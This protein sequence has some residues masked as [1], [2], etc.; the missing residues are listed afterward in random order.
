MKNP[1]LTEIEEFFD[2]LINYP[3]NIKIDGH[4]YSE[5]AIKKLIKAEIIIL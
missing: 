3:K 5:N 4:L 1:Y 2:N